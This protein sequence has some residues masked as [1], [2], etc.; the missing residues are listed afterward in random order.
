MGIH[1]DPACTGLSEDLIEFHNG[2]QTRSDDIIEHVAGSHGGQLVDVAHQDEGRPRG[3]GLHKMV[4]HDRIDHRCL[5]YHQQIAVEGSVLRSLESSL[6]EAELEEPMNRLRLMT[7]CLTHAF[8][9]PA[10]WRRKLHLRFQPVED[11]DNGVD[12]GG[13][14]R[15]G[16]AR[17][18]HH[19]AF[20]GTPD[21]LDLFL[22][23]SD[24]QLPLYPRNGFV[25]FVHP[26][27]FWDA[28]QFLELCGNTGFTKVK[29][30]QVDPSAVPLVFLR[31]LAQI[32]DH[33]LSGLVDVADRCCY[34]LAVDL[35]NF[36]A[37]FHELLI[38]IV[39]VTFVRELLKDIQDACL[40]P[41]PG[42]FGE[43]E[44]FCNT[45]GR[46]KTDS[47]DIRC[48]AVGVLLY[49]RNGPVPVL[50][51]YLGCIARTHAMGL[52]EDHHIPDLFLLF[53]CLS[54]HP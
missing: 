28:Q 20:Q 8:R 13:L 11:L 43:P 15:A 34:K 32:L 47:E 1:Y 12:D 3:N 33:N 35:E 23:Q 40:D 25:R 19:L 45:V 14:A 36:A 30:L 22:C 52:Q 18:D 4:H 41:W 2:Y 7:G 51:E 53:P 54:Y 37:L 46:G 17:D 49:N 16:S 6:S 9:S 48:E 27:S 26:N 29:C 44:L 5:I 39:D 50:L 24:G 38:G 21:R 10:R 31:G 42:V